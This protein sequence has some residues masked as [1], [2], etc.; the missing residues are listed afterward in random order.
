MDS[1]SEKLPETFLVVGGSKIYVFQ[2]DVITLGRALDNDLIFRQP[3][4]SR[5]HAK[6]QYQDGSFEIID[7]KSTGGTYVNGNK[8]DRC[9][10]S[11]GDVIT[12]TNL[13]LVFGQDVDID[14]DKVTTYEPP[15]L[16]DQS[17]RNTDILGK[18]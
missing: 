15:I 3:Q 9:A 16:K 6:I 14:T 1:G 4:I 12:L 8:I 17:R 7:L 10:L 5:K 11:K 13:H 18:K 2:K